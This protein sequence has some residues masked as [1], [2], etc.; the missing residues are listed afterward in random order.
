M[1]VFDKGYINRFKRI[2]FKQPLING[3]HVEQIY[4]KL[5]KTKKAGNEWV[6]T[7]KSFSE[8]EICPYKGLFRSCIGCAQSTDGNEGENCRK[9]A[10]VVDSIELAAR[11]TD[12]AAAGLEIEVEYEERDE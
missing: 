7:Y 8:F 2:T 12:C 10:E 1:K 5:P 9:L 6:V 11:Y 3:R 4:T